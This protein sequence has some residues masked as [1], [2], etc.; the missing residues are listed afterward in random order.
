MGLSKKLRNFL[1]PGFFPFALAFIF[2]SLELL[3]YLAE[4]PTPTELAAIGERFYKDYGLW[5]VFAAAV[6]EGLFMVN[7]YFPGSF[8]IVLAVII[9]PHTFS[10]LAPIALIVWLAFLLAGSI[11][12]CL[13]KFGFYKALL[14]LGH[15]SIIDRTQQWMDRKGKWAI[16]IAGVHQNILAVMQ[17]CMGIARV[18]VLKTLVLSAVS[19]AI[20]IPVSTVVVAAIFSKTVLDSPYFVYFVAMAFVVWGLYLCFS[21]FYKKDVLVKIP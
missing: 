17:V 10:A 2:L 15:R 20:W 16:F 3:W 21:D 1:A 18:G 5:V 11:N 4:L 9:V 12:Y 19:L 8:V 14:F 13:G 7:F 6:I